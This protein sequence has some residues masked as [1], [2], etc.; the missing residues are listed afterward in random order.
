MGNYIFTTKVLLDALNQDAEDERSLHDMGGNILPM[1]TGAGQVQVYD[2]DQNHV[3]GETPRDHGYWRDV[4]TLDAYYDSHM[5]LISV[6]PVFNLYNHDWPIYTHHRPLPPAKIVHDN[7]RVV[8]SML[9]NGVIV[10]DSLV[11]GSVLSPRVKIDEKAEVSGSVLM[12]N[13]QI[14][15]GSIIRN[16]ILDKNVIVP[17]GAR[18]G[19]DLERDRARFTVSDNG[20]VVIGKNATI[21]V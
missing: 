19:V 8:D 3:P 9:S 12:D 10:A 18:I 15:A 13:V 11:A 6:H 20:I 1:L 5:D 4:G 17:P 14:G 2:F 7:T 21:D 16:A